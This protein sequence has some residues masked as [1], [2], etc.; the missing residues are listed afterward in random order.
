VREYKGGYCTLLTV[1]RRGQKRL[2]PVA[3]STTKAKKAVITSS[4]VCIGSWNY[5]AAIIKGIKK[6][7]FAIITIFQNLFDKMI[8]YIF[9]EGDDDSPSWQIADLILQTFLLNKYH[10]FNECVMTDKDKY[11]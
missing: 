3:I 8:I 4:L 1:A 11:S 5:L 9:K 10:S 7:P 6:P 2:F